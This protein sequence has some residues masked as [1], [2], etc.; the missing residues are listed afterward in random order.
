[1]NPK[2]RDSR[3]PFSEICGAMVAYKL[4]QVLYEEWNVP[5]K[6]W[7]DMLELAAIATVGDVM[8]LKDENRIVVKEGLKRLAFTK[9]LGLK[10]LIEKNAL[11]PSAITAYHIGFVL[12]PCLNAGGRLQTA[13]MAVA[14][15]LSRE[16]E[17]AD[18][19]AD[20]LKALN[21]QRKD[22]T[23][24]GVEM[25]SALVEECYM[26][27]KVLTV[28]LP[29]CHESLAGIIAGRHTGALPQADI[30]PDPLGGLRQGL[31]AFH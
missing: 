22:M 31:R 6:E 12:G 13:R 14:L 21:D 4:I 29:D 2:R 20:E 1:M 9:N 23:Q 24:E 25:A 30:Y 8:K 19:L 5:K 15:L 10:K 27:N 28:F 11:D 16:E 7:L 17:E 18:R 3:Y 26:G